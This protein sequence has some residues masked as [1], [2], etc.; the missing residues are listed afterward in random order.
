MLK[1]QKLAEE[2]ERKKKTKVDKQDDDSEDDDSVRANTQIPVV[3]TNS[4]Q[5][6]TPIGKALKKAQLQADKDTGSS[7][8]T[9][10]DVIAPSFNGN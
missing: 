8:V 6:Q 4:D 9:F 2:T 1:A 10:K 7:L 3:E 5:T